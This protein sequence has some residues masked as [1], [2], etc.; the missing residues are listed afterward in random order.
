MP[1]PAP[2]PTM[3]PSMLYSSSSSVLVCVCRAAQ[4]RSALLFSVLCCSAPLLSVHLK[5]PRPRRE[6]AQRNNRRRSRQ[7]KARQGKA[8]Q[9]EAAACRHDR[10]TAGRETSVSAV[11]QLLWA[12]VIWRPIAQPRSLGV[13][14]R[15]PRRLQHGQRTH[16]ITIVLFCGH[17][18]CLPQLLSAS[19]LPTRLLSL[20]R[21]AC[22]RRRVCGYCS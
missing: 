1:D 2:S 3:F 15:L 17:A 21:S 12:T 13:S 4:L 14:S 22:F 10:S 6:S 16:S 5:A 9:G 18:V 11:L 7:G 20:L 19:V 8:R